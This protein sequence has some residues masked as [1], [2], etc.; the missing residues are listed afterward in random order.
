MYTIMYDVYQSPGMLP[1]VCRCHVNKDLQP[2]EEGGPTFVTAKAYAEMVKEQAKQL[3]DGYHTA[4]LKEDKAVLPRVFQIGPNQH[5]LRQNQFL[6]FK[7]RYTCMMRDMGS[8][9]LAAMKTGL[10]LFKLLRH[11][12]LL[13]TELQGPDYGKTVPKLVKVSMAST[14]AGRPVRASERLYQVDV[15]FAYRAWGRWRGVPVGMYGA[16]YGACV[17]E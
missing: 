2:A 1:D 5:V 13:P 14:N 3:F 9:G 10:P 16:A 17:V 8:C 15:S 7:E 4:A 11:T 12:N 6:L